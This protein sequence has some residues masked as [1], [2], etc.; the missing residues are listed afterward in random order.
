VHRTAEVTLEDATEVLAV[1]DRHRVVQAE[2][3]AHA[4]DIGVGDLGLAT[5]HRQ[6]RITGN[7]VHHPEDHDGHAEQ[8][9]H[10]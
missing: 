4:R 10:R 1:L 3:L 5:Q 8:D 6:G 9:G 2:L 7:Q